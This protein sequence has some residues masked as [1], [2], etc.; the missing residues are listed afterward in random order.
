MMMCRAES[1][2]FLF[3]AVSP[4]KTNTTGCGF[5]LTFRMM[6]SVNISHPLPLCELG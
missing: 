6:A 4:H 1:M 5:S 2:S 3:S